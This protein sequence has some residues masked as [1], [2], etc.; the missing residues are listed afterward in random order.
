M[1]ALKK[2]QVRTCL[3]HINDSEGCKALLLSQGKKFAHKQIEPLLLIHLAAL[4][5]ERMQV[6]MGR[7]ELGWYPATGCAYKNGCCRPDKIGILKCVKIYRGE[8][9]LD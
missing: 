8:N 4:R 2:T 1:N 3:L 9:R 6:L 5:I 7:G